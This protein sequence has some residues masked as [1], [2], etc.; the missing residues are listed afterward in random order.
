[1]TTTRHYGRDRRPSRRPVAVLLSLGLLLL[2]GW[3][4]ASGRLEQLNPRPARPA[5]PM[6]ITIPAIGLKA[7]IVRVGLAADGAMQLPKPDQVGWYDRGPWPGE[8]GPAVLVGHVDDRT[9]P[10]VFYR[11]RQLRPG[12][13]ILVGQR[14]GSTA[15]FRV[16]RL[17]R[18]PKDAL[19]TRRIWAATSEPV[20]RLITCGGSFNHTTGH[21]RDNLIVYAAPTGS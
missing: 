7:G 21:Y 20:L 6:A 18:H 9:G 14:D 5:G 4:L 13:E 15:R 3:L 8:P 1:V 2:M 16:Q 12:D 17:E 10:A 11:L 19:P